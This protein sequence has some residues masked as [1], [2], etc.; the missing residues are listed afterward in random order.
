VPVRI[1]VTKALGPNQPLRPGM[2]V[3]AHIDTKSPAGKC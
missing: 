3:G 2:S 1:K